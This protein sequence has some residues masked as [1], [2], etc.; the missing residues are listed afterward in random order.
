[1]DNLAYLA[2]FENETK[3]VLKNGK[4]IPFSSCQAS[5][6]DTQVENGW[7][8]EITGNEAAALIDKPLPIKT[9]VMDNEVRNILINEF[10]LDMT[11]FDNWDFV[12]LIYRIQES[13]IA[14]GES[15]AKRKMEH[16][17]DE[18]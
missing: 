5:Y 4:S 10:E 9:F 3:I 11:N 1:M 17:L 16:C 12:S 7:W 13:G 15:I 14:K 2:V 8:K 6:C 18:I